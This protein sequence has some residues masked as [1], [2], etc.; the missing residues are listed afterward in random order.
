MCCVAFPA[1]IASSPSSTVISLYVRIE[2]RSSLTYE[3]TGSAEDHH[4]W[5]FD[6]LGERVEL[7]VTALLLLR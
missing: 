4:A 1:L 6:R 7:M 5:A 2:R 3:L